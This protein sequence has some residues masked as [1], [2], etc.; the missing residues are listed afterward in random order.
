[1][2]GRRGLVPLLLL[3]YTPYIGFTDDLYLCLCLTSA[4]LF[5]VQQTTLTAVHLRV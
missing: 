4:V 3:Y 2:N 1:M 5:T